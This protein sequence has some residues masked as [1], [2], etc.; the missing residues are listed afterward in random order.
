MAKAKVPFDPKH[1]VNLDAEALA[2]GVATVARGSAGFLVGHLS[3]LRTAL[4]P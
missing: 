3:K 4:V 2:V 1:Q